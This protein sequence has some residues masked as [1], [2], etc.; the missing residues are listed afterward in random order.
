MTGVRGADGKVE[1]GV[2]G[3]RVVD[4][5]AHGRRMHPPGPPRSAGGVPG[6]A[7]RPV[8]HSEGRGA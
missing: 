3:R 6:A 1:C 8:R 2:C 4:L 7:M 5:L